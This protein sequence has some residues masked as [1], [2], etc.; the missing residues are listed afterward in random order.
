MEVFKTTNVVVWKKLMD[1]LNIRLV[2]FS[3]EVLSTPT[4]SGGN[5]RLGD[6]MDEVQKIRKG[7]TTRSYLL[8]SLA[9]ETKGGE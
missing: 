9:G 3:R 4:V 8:T 1:R 2:P 5:I 6:V 7:S